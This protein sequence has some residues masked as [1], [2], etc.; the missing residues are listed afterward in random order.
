MILLLALGLAMDAFAV[1][2]SNGMRRRVPLFKNALSSGLAFGI[3]QGLMP[4]IGYFAGHGFHDLIERIDHW[5]ALVLLSVI[6]G[7]MIHGAW[8]ERGQAQEA[9]GKG[10]S[11]PQLMLQA[12]ATSIDA[13]VI[14]VTLGFMNVNIWFAVS[15]IGAVTFLCSFSGVL[16]GRLFGGLLRDKAVYL[17]GAILILIGVNIFGEHMGFWH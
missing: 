15:V 12:L 10:L 4:L 9:S 8:K 17:G 6:G 14:G 2:V 11:L 7:R 1:S 13:L 16:I 5:L 3:A